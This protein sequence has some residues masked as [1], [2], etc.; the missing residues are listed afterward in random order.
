[1]LLALDAGLILCWLTGELTGNIKLNEKKSETYRKELL[2]AIQIFGSQR[3]IAEEIN[4]Y[5]RLH[6]LNTRQVS[7][8]NI[9]NW[10]NR[11]KKIARDYPPVIE[12]I[13]NGVIRASALRGD[14]KT[15]T[16]R[17]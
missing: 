12:V 16:R 1:V 13:T 9:S 17:R 3:Q 5:I 4:T 11:D 14:G 10:L 8:Q 7:Q 15:S 6:K 2:K